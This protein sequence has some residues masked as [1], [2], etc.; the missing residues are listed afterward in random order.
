MIEIREFTMQD[1]H[2]ALALWK[3]SEGIS[4][5][6]ADSPENIKYFLERN[7]GM[8]FVAYD[9]DHL[10]GAAM[11]GH[12][13]RRGYLHHVAVAHGNRRRGIGSAL[14]LK[15][16]DKLR[17]CGIH[18]CHLFVERENSQALA[19][20]KGI[21]WFERSDLWMMSRDLGSPPVKGGRPCSDG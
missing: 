10:V 2:A 9:G 15:C 11:C 16:L 17:A 12:D 3:E 5:R 13:G 7:P 4:L 6:E 19:F 14:A 8:S 20:W 18:R 1:Y 21:G